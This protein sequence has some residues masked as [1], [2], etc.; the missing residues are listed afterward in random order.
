MVILK[1]E[2]MALTIWINCPWW[3]DNPIDWVYKGPTVA[4]L[5]LN[6]VFLCAIMWVLITKLRSA[7][8]LETQQYRKAAK[9]LV[10]LKPLLGVTYILTITVPST[11]QLMYIFDYMRAVLLSTQV[12]HYSCLIYKKKCIIIN[13][14]LC[15]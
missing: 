1:E 13:I 5:L 7:N 8:T 9:A 11:E 10:V 12:N 6:L 2:A 15:V 4:I 14:F 3:V